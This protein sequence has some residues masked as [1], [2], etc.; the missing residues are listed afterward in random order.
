M[1]WGPPC[2]SGEEEWEGCCKR[3]Q[4]IICWCS[5]T[6]SSLGAGN[7]IY[8]SFPSISDGFELRRGLWTLRLVLLSPFLWHN[9]RSPLC[10]T[11]AL[12]LCFTSWL[13]EW[14]YPL[15]DFGFL[16]A[17][18]SLPCLHILSLVGSRQYAYNVP[19]H[20]SFIRNQRNL[21]IHTLSGRL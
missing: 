13:L 17:V 10:Y 14:V 15:Q 7:S 20:V 6:S 1:K 12:L 2:V 21:W 18:L 11:S 5:L 16:L 9:P 19:F 3:N 8:L 4:R